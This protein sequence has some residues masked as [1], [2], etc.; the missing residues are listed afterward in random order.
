FEG[1]S[2]AE[3]MS[4]HLKQAVP[5][6]RKFV[7][8]ISEDF[9]HVLHKLLAKNRAERYQTPEDLAEDLRTFQD[10]SAPRLARAHAAR[11]PKANSTAR[12]PIQ[13]RP[14]WI[15][16]AVAG[17]VVAIGLAGWLMLPAPGP[18]KLAAPAPA[19][20]PTATVKPVEPKGPEKTDDP[21]RLDQATRLLAKG[22][23]AFGAERWG[24]ASDTLQQL[25]KSYDSLDFVRSRSSSI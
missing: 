16:Y 25:Q 1:K 3:T 7:P 12:I 11:A 13:R 10:G 14:V 18:V 21:A 24:E 15:P 4:M 8:K 23:K 2:A 22:E 5:D 20:A 17:G 9:S 6:V 19:A